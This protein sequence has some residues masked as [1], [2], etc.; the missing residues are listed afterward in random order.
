MPCGICTV[1]P[2][3]VGGSYELTRAGWRVVRLRDAGYVQIG[4]LR[5]RSAETGWLGARARQPAGKL[6]PFCRRTHTNGP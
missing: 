2:G 4:P 1:V 3:R 5:Q 6:A